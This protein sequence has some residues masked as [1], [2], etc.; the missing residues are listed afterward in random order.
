MVSHV[1]G[2]S[3]PHKIAALT[4][5]YEQHPE[6][7]AKISRIVG[8]SIAECQKRYKTCISPHQKRELVKMKKEGL[9]WK[10]ITKQFNKTFNK[11][12]RKSQLASC[13]GNIEQRG[14]PKY[15]DVYS[16]FPELDPKH[17]PRSSKRKV[18]PLEMSELENRHS[19]K[20]HK[21]QKSEAVTVE[22]LDMSEFVSFQQSN[23]DHDPSKD[24]AH[25]DAEF[26]AHMFSPKKPNIQSPVEEIDEA[27]SSPQFRI[28]PVQ[29]EDLL[30]PNENAGEEITNPSSLFNPF[31]PPVF[32]P[33]VVESKSK[34]AMGK[35][36]DFW[37]NQSS[38]DPSDDFLMRATLS[39][40]P[41]Y[42]DPFGLNAPKD[43][44]DDTAFP[45]SSKGSTP[46]NF[47]D[48]THEE[49]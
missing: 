16:K 38:F 25:R 28:P 11:E 48:M 41:S 21:A 23:P 17:R 29:T 26:V 5:A 13:V 15:S 18:Q 20:K 2:G 27:P 7:W 9:G 49:R 10:E 45:T 22:P 32:T 8:W 35:G 1:R 31:T 6:Q 39:R 24:E 12:C 30:A 34:E 19:G 46:F 42:S 40:A 44:W 43:L 14:K 4:E 37:G 47:D 3:S 36:D 33:P